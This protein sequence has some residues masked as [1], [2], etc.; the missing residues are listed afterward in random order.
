MGNHESPPRPVGSKISE[1]A[2]GYIMEIGLDEEDNI[3]DRKYVNMGAHGRHQSWGRCSKG[4]GKGRRTYGRF[5]EA[6][7]TIDPR[8]E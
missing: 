8:K 7:K 3:I 1:L 5:D 6:V 2:E 4:Y